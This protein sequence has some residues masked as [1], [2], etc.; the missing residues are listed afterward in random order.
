MK[1]KILIMILLMVNPSTIFA[2]NQINMNMQIK[3]IRAVG[4]YAGTT[5]DNT[6]ELHFTTPLSWPAGSACTNTKRVMIDSKHTHLISAA[7][8]AFT[9]DRKVNI[10]TDT[11]L[12]NRNGACEVSYLDILE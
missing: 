2:D 1:I 4:D 10:N 6:I 7:Y 11:T 12:P 3:F 5:Y 8:A 9:T